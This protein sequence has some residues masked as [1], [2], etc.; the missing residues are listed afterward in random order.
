MYI[1]FSFTKKKK[2][3]EKKSLLIVLM[4]FPVI[5]EDNYVDGQAYTH[6]LENKVSRLEEENERLRRQ[7]V[8]FI[9]FTL[10]TIWLF[11]LV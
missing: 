2:N 3:K 9:T 11:I 5:L 10:E 4:F 8:G 1:F 7:K 6:E